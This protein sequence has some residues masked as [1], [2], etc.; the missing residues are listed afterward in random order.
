MGYKLGF[1]VHRGPDQGP[2]TPVGGTDTAAVDKGTA[3]GPE[4]VAVHKDYMLGA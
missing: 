2:G 4:E 1:V 3:V